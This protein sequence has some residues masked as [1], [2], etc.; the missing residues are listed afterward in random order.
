[1]RFYFDFA[2]WRQLR[3]AGHA[4]CFFL[5][6]ILF[7][8]LR[9]VEV[10]APVFV[11]GHARSGTTLAHRLLCADPQFS[12]FK[13]WELR[14]PALVEKKTVHLL[15]WLDSHLFGRRLAKR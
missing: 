2:T 1:M 10:T 6:G 13:Y 5:D 15:A 3:A 9:T 11:I 7:P 14:L 12:A 4:I 8:G